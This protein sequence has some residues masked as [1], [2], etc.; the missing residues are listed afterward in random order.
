MRLAEADAALPLWQRSSFRADNAFL[1][2]TRSGFQRLQ[3]FSLWVSFP[4]LTRASLLAEYTTQKR[5]AVL[6]AIAMELHRRRHGAWPRSLD[7]LSPQLLPTVPLDRYD[8][9]PLKYRVADGRPLLYSIGADRDDDGG[10]LPQGEHANS[11]AR[12]WFPPS[13]LLPE[14]R[15]G[16]S[17][18]L[19]DGDWILWPP[20]D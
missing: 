17:P 16:F 13:Y 19:P 10:R 11:R 4:S 8:G 18:P 15:R 2:S 6:V 9:K 5:D 12:E 3:Y 1:R 14:V 7:Q 20:V